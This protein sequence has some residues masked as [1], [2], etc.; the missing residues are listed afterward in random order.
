MEMNKEQLIL[1][2]VEEKRQDIIDFVQKMVQIPSVTNNE[3]AIGDAFYQDMKEKMHLDDVQMIEAEPGHPN[4]I[5]RVKGQGDGPTLTFNGHMDVIFE[6]P[7]ED[8]TYPPYSGEIVDGKLYGRGSVDMKS[9][10]CS[11]VLAAWIIKELGLPLKGD[12]QLT[13]VCDEEICGD[14]GICYLLKEGYVKKEHENDMGINCEPTKCKGGQ[15]VVVAHKG[16]LRAHFHVHGKNAHGARP[17]LGINA[18][19]KAAKLVNRIHLLEEQIKV[20]HHPM[21]ETPSIL[22]AMMKGGQALNML[23]SECTVSVTRRMLPGESKEEAVAQYQKIIDDLAAEDSDFKADL[24]IYPGFRPPMDIGTDNEITR[25]VQKAYQT[26]T[27]KELPMVAEEGGTDAT[28]VVEATGI[29]MPVFGPGDVT[30]CAALDEAVELEDI[31]MAVKV[32]AL[33][34]YYALGMD[35]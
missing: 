16:I 9:G 15:R 35:A 7:A 13:V 25:I 19:E 5:A 8:W 11:S 28:F 10:T 2:K 24:E 29:P 34:I 32:Y 27:G 17:W 30:L 22:I 23:P 12:V 33:A 20:K 26:V 31:I 14:R 21:L 4:I 3:A 6:G 18:I 1:N